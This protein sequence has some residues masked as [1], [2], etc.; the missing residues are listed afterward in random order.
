M[1]GPPWVAVLA[2]LAVGWLV[3]GGLFGGFLLPPGLGVLALLAVFW[4]LGRV[5]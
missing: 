5:D 3:I 1:T 4:I 2:I